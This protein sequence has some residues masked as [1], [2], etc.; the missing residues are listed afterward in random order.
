[1]HFIYAQ[2]RVLPL[3]AQRNGE[4]RSAESGTRSVRITAACYVF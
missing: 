1:V 4:A 2:C 3:N